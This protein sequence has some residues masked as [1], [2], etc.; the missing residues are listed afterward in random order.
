MRERNIL[1]MAEP[2][3]ILVVDDNEDLLKTFSLILKRTG[4]YVETAADGFIAVDRY[5]HG[6]FNVT[7][8]DI[9]LP[10]INGVEAF[11]LIR[12]MDPA[13]PVI[14]MTGYSDE[15]LIQLAI[16]E[17][18]YCVLHKPIRIDKIMDTI[19]QAVPSSPFFK[20]E[21]ALAVKIMP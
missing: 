10:G 7:L 14:L 17:G 9:D 18:A 6:D 12:E 20:K 3:R 15:D 8:M 1:S 19:K 11:R 21:S 2:L 5:L 16:D 4:F 13:A